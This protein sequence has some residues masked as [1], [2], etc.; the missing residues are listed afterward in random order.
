MKRIGNK[1]LGAID[2][3]YEIVSPSVEAA[4]Q[5]QSSQ[6]SRTLSSHGVLKFIHR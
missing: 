3:T 4:S 1:F 5:K 6:A 2:I